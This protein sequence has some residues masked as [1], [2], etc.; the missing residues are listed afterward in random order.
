MHKATGVVAL[1]LIALRIFY[2]LFNQY[3]ELPKG[4]PKL[5]IMLAKSNYLFLYILMLVMPASGLLGS[6]LAGYNVSVF[7][8]F[9]INGF[10]KNIEIAKIMWQIHG[11]CFYCFLVSISAHLLGAIYHHFIIKDNLVT[12]MIRGS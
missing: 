3:P 6:L 5:N 12:R 1:V 10:E 7:D 11:I 4:T 9:L 2:R 8:L